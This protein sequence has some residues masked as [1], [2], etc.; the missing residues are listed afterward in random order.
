MFSYLNL[1]RQ[2]LAEGVRQK[3]RTGIDTF[4]IPGGMMQFDHGM[5]L[6]IVTTKKVNFD[7]IK[8]EL[9]GFIRGVTSAK[10][11]RNLG[12]KIWDANAN[13]NETWLKNPH[14][15]GLDDLGPIYGKQWRNWEG[16]GEAEGTTADRWST[17]YK[18]Y[19]VDQLWTVVDKILNNPQDR[20]MI[21]TAW[22]PAEVHKMALPP[23]HLL[24]QFL[25]QQEDRKLHMTMYMRSC[26]MF[27]GVPFNITSYALLQALVAKATGYIPGKLTMFLA[28]VHIYENHI[29]Q[30]QEQLQRWP[31]PKPKLVFSSQADAVLGSTD[32]IGSNRAM[33][34]LDTLAP[35]DL[36]LE[37]Y[38]PYPPIKAEM[39]V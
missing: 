3:N 18:E 4:M 36:S 38:D 9:I 15:K 21:V 13:A 12:T 26:D 16:L 30:V 11:F 33:Q 2:T 37:G 24:Y 31:R 34:F 25:V 32:Q 19:K 10:D 17:T 20:R 7:A 5:G 29:A 27:L 1:L 14:R 22:N 8:A 28:D 6:P 35:G 39:A 23:C